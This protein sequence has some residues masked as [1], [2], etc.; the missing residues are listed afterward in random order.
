[1]NVFNY[2]AVSISTAGSIIIIWDVMIAIFINGVTYQIDG[3]VS[4]ENHMYRVDPDAGGYTEGW[5]LLNLTDNAGAKHRLSAV[6]RLKN[7][8]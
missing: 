5:M 1:M 4:S 6:F 7:K 3:S 2:I 8:S